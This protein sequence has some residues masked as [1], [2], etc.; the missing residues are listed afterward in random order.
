MRST[1]LI[2]IGARGARAFGDGFTALLLPVYLTGLGFGPFR[3]GVITT[4]TLLGSALLTLVV[5]HLGHRLAARRVLMGCCALMLATGVGFSQ[6]QAF[7]PLLLVGFLGT[8]NPSG[9]GAGGGGAGHRGTDGRGVPAL[10]QGVVGAGLGGG[11]DLHRAGDG[12]RAVDQPGHHD[13]QDGRQQGELHRRRPTLGA[14][15]MGERGPP[16]GS[17]NSHGSG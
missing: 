9:D 4:A 8:L 17:G 15:Q 12:A 5:G 2:L 11:P 13:Q 6:L 7:W 14:A 1:A 3:V 16:Q 10:A